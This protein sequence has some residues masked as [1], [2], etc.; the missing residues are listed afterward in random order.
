MTLLHSTNLV[1]A[2]NRNP[3]AS[4]QA[5]KLWKAFGCSL[6]Q[7]FFLKVRIFQF[8]RQ[9]HFYC[10]WGPCCHGTLTV[11]KSIIS[12][13]AYLYQVFIFLYFFFHET[14]RP[15]KIG[16]KWKAALAAIWYIKYSLNLR[17]SVAAAKFP[18]ILRRR[19]RRLLHVKQR[20]LAMFLFNAV[21]P[22]PP[23]P[24]PPHPTPH[25][26]T[27]HPPNGFSPLNVSGNFS[28]GGEGNACKLNTHLPPKRGVFF[29]L[30][31]VSKGEGH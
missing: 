13:F 11:R 28:K 3:F 27:P 30:T 29:I 9:K 12:V 31:L 2:L 23:Q 5:P 10:Q 26:P 16:L 19:C 25:H 17:L 22:R 4:H 6:K 15:N 18:Q 14:R 21:T 24:T 8:I 7:T 20:P 1:E